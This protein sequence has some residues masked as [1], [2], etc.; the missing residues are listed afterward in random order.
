MRKN[1]SI[2]AIILII[3]LFLTA[4]SN[5]NSSKKINLDPK[6]PVIV[7]LITYYNDKQ[8]NEIKNIVSTFNE[9]VGTDEGIIVE[10]I[11]AGSISQANKILIDSANNAPGSIEFPDM[12]ITYKGTIMDLKD[13]VE[14]IDFKEYFSDEELKQY[15]PNLLEIGK[16]EDENK[17][18]MLPM[19]S[20]TI[21]TFINKTDFD[22]ISKAAGI[23]YD[24]LKTYEGIVSSAEK[25]YNYTD[26]LTPQKND[27]KALY[28]TD[29]VVEQIFSMRKA[30]G[31]E[32]LTKKNDKIQLNFDKETARKLWDIFYVPTM[33]GHF[34]KYG[35]F[36]SED[37]KTGKLLLSTASTSGASYFPNK[38]ME[39]DGK[40]R[41]IEIGTMF[42]PY[43]E[44]DEQLTVQ[45]G[46]GIFIT[47]S[48]PVKEY[49]SSIFVKWLTNKENNTMFTLRSSYIPVRN[50]NTDTDYV[51]EEIKNI[52]LNQTIAS[53]IIT[54]IEQT[55]NRK[56]YVSPNIEG[57][58][59]TRV[60]VKEIFDIDIQ[61]KRKEL[62]NKVSQGQNYDELLKESISEESFEKWYEDTKAKLEENL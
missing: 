4:C 47:K 38:I 7:S 55:K 52:N 59:D 24:D 41:Q 16:F 42:S 19:G 39:E 36:T 37:V 29:A 20:S 9:T 27:G 44:N 8:L 50:D 21:I 58:E 6:N 53:S 26:S 31:E 51:K 13:K 48:T 56:S 23:S 43:I 22:K 25:Y 12:F 54:S 35:K 2:L 49:A 1:T 32:L 57:Y 28:G 11:G 10:V 18:S 3:S 61:E 45:Q 40:E 17:I 33:K 34:A 5:N 62:L 14:V 60:V 30:M 46:G 15:L